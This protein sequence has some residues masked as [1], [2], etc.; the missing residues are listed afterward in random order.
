MGVLFALGTLVV[1]ALFVY[2][3]EHRH[4]IRSGLLMYASFTGATA[5]G[6]WMM[7]RWGR[8][9]AL[10]VALG[11]A[12]LGTLTLLSTLATHQG[13]KVLP[14][15][16]LGTNVVLGYLLGLRVFTLPDEH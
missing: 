15:A 11:N 13:S 10:V 16:L 2:E 6:M 14:A 4:Q 12:G 1:G 8:A 3:L 9:L 5:Y 7:R